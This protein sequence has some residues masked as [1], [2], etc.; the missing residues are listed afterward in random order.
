[1]WYIEHVNFP[2]FYLNAER[3]VYEASL[4]DATAFPNEMDAIATAT[5]DLREGMWRVVQK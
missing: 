2:G 4:S 1:M 3:H 5:H